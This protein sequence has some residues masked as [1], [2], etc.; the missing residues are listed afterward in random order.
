MPVE[1]QYKRYGKNVGKKNFRIFDIL[2]KKDF[3]IL[4]QNSKKDFAENEITTLIC[5]MD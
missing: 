3:A 2:S 1:K 4:T 5:L